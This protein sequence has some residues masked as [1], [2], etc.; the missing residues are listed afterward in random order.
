MTSQPSWNCGEEQGWKMWMFLYGRWFNSVMKGET[1]RSLTWRVSCCP[2][3]TSSS[4]HPSPA[5]CYQKSA[6]IITHHHWFTWTCRAAQPRQ[7]ALDRTMEDLLGLVRGLM[8]PSGSS[9]YLTQC[10]PSL[11]GGVE[12]SV[13]WLMDQSNHHVCLCGKGDGEIFGPFTHVYQ[14]FKSVYLFGLMLR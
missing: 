12:Q 3:F 14:F 9:R 13:K 7:M 5:S 10:R 4:L 1:R 2:S 6:D 11:V 8:G